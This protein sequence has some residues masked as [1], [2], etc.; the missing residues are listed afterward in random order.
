MINNKGQYIENL[1][2]VS[3]QEEEHE[4]SQFGRAVFPSVPGT[5]KVEKHC[6]GST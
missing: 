6:Q 2:Y 4:T 3:G 5:K 1:K